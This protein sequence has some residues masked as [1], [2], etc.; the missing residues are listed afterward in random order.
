MRAALKKYENDSGV[1]D[2]NIPYGWLIADFMIQG[3]KAAGKNP[4]RS[5]FLAATKAIKNYSANGLLNPAVPS[6]AASINAKA[7]GAPGYCQRLVHLE[8]KQ[9]V[10]SGEICGKLLHGFGGE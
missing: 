5:S 7:L 6:V 8:G 4:T 9:F 1:P 3:L 10:P 2:L